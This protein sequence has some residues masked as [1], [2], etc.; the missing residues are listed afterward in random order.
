M[1]T[2]GSNGRTP[3][4]EAPGAPAPV[5]P[6]RAVGR[7]WPGDAIPRLVGLGVPVDEAHRLVNRHGQPRVTDAVD[8]LEELDRG[9]RIL[10]PV[11]W[12]RAA[13][14]QGWDL[15][16]VLAE[17][18]AR[19]ERLAALEVDRQ[20]READ[21]D[22][23]PERR[24]TSERWA[25]AVSTALDDGQLGAAIAAVARPVPGLDRHSTPVVRAEL[26]QWAVEVHRRHPDTGLREALQAD[27]ERGPGPLEPTSWPLPDPPGLP[28]GAAERRP[29]TS[30]IEQVLGRQ[31]GQH[32]HDRSQVATVELHR[33]VQF[34]PGGGR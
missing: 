12:V 9:G 8:A 7:T 11:G 24:R 14:E 13:V 22:A 20:R 25:R 34:E 21:A 6:R 31:V 30:R 10:A 19:D 5:P 4:P 26:V 15:A 16:P 27:L 23:F 17:R 29:L 33:A 2:T 18:R 28:D 3:A 32:G 1:D